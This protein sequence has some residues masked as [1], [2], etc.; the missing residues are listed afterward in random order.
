[1]DSQTDRYGLVKKHEVTLKGSSEGVFKES[2]AG[3]TRAGR[4]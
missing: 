4:S 1:M 3:R 2:G